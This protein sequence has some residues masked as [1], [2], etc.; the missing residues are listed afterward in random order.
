MEHASTRS[1]PL[2]P[3]SVGSRPALL[4]MKTMG[5][6]ARMH[7]DEFFVWIFAQWQK[8]RKTGDTG[9][10]TVLL[11]SERSLLTESCCKYVYACLFMHC[12]VLC[13]VFWPA[14]L[15]PWDQINGPCVT[16]IDLFWGQWNQHRVRNGLICGILWF[17]SV[18]GPF[19]CC[20]EGYGGLH[21]PQ[22]QHGCGVRQPWPLTGTHQHWSAFASM[23]RRQQ[24]R[25]VGMHVCMHLCINAHSMHVYQSYIGGLIIFTVLAYLLS[26]HCWRNDSC[27]W[28]SHPEG[29]GSVRGGGQASLPPQEIFV[30][31]RHLL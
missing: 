17:P 9:R 19:G 5:K 13:L 10:Q 2:E 24:R 18:S 23:A 14:T 20:W 30:Q 12:T 16:V 4:N 31:Q 15:N 27:D 26:S 6:I 25:A 28:L 8:K 22:R 21:S 29:T 7:Q 11:L 1:F 3:L